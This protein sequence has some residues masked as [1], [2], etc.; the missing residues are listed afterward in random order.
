M[1]ESVRFMTDI[2]MRAVFEGQ[3]VSVLELRGGT[4]L[5][6]K[7]TDSD[8]IAEREARFDLMV[9][10]LRELRERLKA[11][12]HSPTNIEAIPSIDHEIFKVTEPGGNI[13]TLFSGHISQ[14]PV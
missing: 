8:S 9:E 4:H 6:I 12:G 2:G 14:F 13:I 5:V 11:L 3:E 10:D 7:L 1:D